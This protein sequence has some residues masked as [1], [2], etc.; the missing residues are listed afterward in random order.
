MTS[1]HRVLLSAHRGAAGQHGLRDNSWEALQA[2]VRLPV[3]YVEFDVH[4]TADG[5]FVLHHLDHV[6]VG[7]RRLYLRHMSARLIGDLVGHPLVEYADALEL[8]AA[9]GKRAHIDL[10]LVSP[11]TA[12]AAERG[13]READDETTAEIA[14]ELEAARTALRIMGAPEAFILTSLEDRSVA[15]LTAWA[16]VHSPGTL[17]GLSLGRTVFG[18]GWWGQVLLRRSELFPQRRMERCGAT[19]VVAQHRLASIRLL[20]WADRHRLPVLVWTVDR[21]RR[22]RRFLRDDRVWMVT[23]NHPSRARHAGDYDA[24]A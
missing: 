14:Y 2:A 21:P 13:E 11:A 20:R 10:K 22:L 4:R 15:V 23:S 6:R 5:R 9:H 16:A 17:V 24:V 18:I 1:G 19:L 8:L 7:R 3:E 12:Y